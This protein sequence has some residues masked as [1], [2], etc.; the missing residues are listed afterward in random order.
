MTKVYFIFVHF[1]K[2][3]IFCLKYQEKYKEFRGKL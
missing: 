1:I 2:N 3:E